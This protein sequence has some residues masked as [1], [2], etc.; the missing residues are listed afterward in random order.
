MRLD[1]LRQ[2]VAVVRRPALQDVGDVDL[3]ALEQDGLQDLVEQ[4]AGAAHERLAL[5]VLVGAGRLADHHQVGALVAGAQDGVDALPVDGH[6][7]GLVEP[8]VDL[9]ER[10]QLVQR[11]VVG[12]ERLDA[13]VGREALVLAGVG[14]G[15]KQVGHVVGGLG[16]ARRGGGRRW[17]GGARQRGAGVRTRSRGAGDDRPSR[18]ARRSLAGRCRRGSG[19]GPRSG[20]GG[21]AP[22]APRAAPRRAAGRAGGGDASATGG[23]GGIGKVAGADGAPQRRCARGGQGCGKL[24]PADGRRAGGS[25]AHARPT[26]VLRPPARRGRRARSGRSRR[27]RRGRRGGGRRPRSGRPGGGTG[28]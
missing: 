28:R 15:A 21:G 18:R 13:V 6:Q 2:R 25:G 26:R 16:S 10:V 14:E 19:R 1:L 12:D 11:R 23:V 4:L 17:A 8:G 9:V 5:A 24:G 3:L 7:L 20:A 27:R 22:P